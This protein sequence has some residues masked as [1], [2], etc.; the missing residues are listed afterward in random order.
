MKQ[1]I[2]YLI[3]ISVAI[4]LAIYILQDFLVDGEIL[5]YIFMALLIFGIDIFT[6]WIY[7]KYIVSIFIPNKIS[8]PNYVRNI[9]NGFIS[10]AAI[11]TGYQIGIN[12]SLN[13]DKEFIPPIER[14]QNDKILIA[15]FFFV[16]ISI[17]VYISY[18]IGYYIKNESKKIDKR[19]LKK[20][21]MKTKITTPIL[22][23]IIAFIIFFIPWLFTRNS[24]F[25]DYSS[26]GEIGDTIG[27]LTAPF[28]NGIAAI[29]VFIAF[30]EQVKANKLLSSQYEY[31]RINN[32][33]D[34]ISDKD[35][36]LN[37]LLSQLQT[38]HGWITNNQHNINNYINLLN[39]ILYFSSDFEVCLNQIENFDGNK[40]LLWKKLYYL[41]VVLHKDSFKSIH[42]ELQNAIGLTNND[43][44]IVEIQLQ[45]QRLNDMIK[46]VN[47]Y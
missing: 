22:I 15:I 19:K 25:P 4:L 1:I 32:Q 23:V 42:T 18:G 3:I 39:K 45:I 29:L 14:L 44:Y 41:Y 47:R 27:G 46:D 35:I 26:T 16:L 24:F 6:K 38:N 10:I 33:I 34:R 20:I 5:H 2:K 13:F 11:I 30:R 28:L 8:I 17:F 21:I 43:V 12:F 36:D 31:D 37:D 9:S 7:N 40:S